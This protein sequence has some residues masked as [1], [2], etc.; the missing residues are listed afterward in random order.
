MRIGQGFDAH[1]LVEGRPL[2]IG[3]VN[4]DWPVGDNPDS[5]FALEDPDA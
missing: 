3:G 1:R 5:P 2:I 4:E